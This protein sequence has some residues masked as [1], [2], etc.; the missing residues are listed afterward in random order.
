MRGQV[1][2]TLVESEADGWS[3]ERTGQQ[4]VEANTADGVQFPVLNSIIQ[5]DSFKTLNGVND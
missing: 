1:S 5:K 4:L 2:N 3:K